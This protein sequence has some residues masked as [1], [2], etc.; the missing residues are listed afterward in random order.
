MLPMAEFA[1]NNRSI[2]GTSFT[3]F[4]LTYGFHLT[5]VAD[6]NLLPPPPAVLGEEAKA[7]VVRMRS[8]FAAF[9]QG[10]RPAVPC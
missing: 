10:L 8:D 5:S 6:A 1:I 7:F 3:P 2:R 4:Y 9:Q